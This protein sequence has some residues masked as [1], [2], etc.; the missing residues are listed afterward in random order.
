MKLIQLFNTAKELRKRANDPDV[1][2]IPNNRFLLLYEQQP[3]LVD[4]FGQEH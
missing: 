3:I 2:A 1:T 4:F